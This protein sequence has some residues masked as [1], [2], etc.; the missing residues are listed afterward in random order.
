M[1]KTAPASAPK[2]HVTRDFNQESREDTCIA[3]DVMFWVRLPYHAQNLH[4]ASEA[5][6]PS[7]KVD[8]TQ[9]IIAS[10]ISESFA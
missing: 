3:R 2:A 7:G 8:V 5:S 1:E 6:R 9:G 10:I 4:S